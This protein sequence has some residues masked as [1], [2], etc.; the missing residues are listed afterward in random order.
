MKLGRLQ[1]LSGTWMCLALS[2][3][4]VL[5]QEPSDWPSFRGPDGKGVV[6]MSGEVESVPLR[7]Q[8]NA[9]PDSGSLDGILWKTDVPGLGH[10]SPVIAGNRIF[11]LTAI[12]STGDA[13]LKVG[14]GGRPEAADDNGEQRWVVLCYDKQTGK[15]LWRNVARQGI[16]K[17]T[18]HA[19]ATHANTS[20]AVAGEHVVA[21]FGSEGLYCYDLEG[22]LQWKRDLGVVDISKYGIGWGYAS[23]PAIYQDR[24]ALICD[25]PNNPYLAVLRLSDGRELWRVSRTDICER[26]WSTPL[27]HA[28]ANRTQIVINGWPWVVSYDLKS[29]GEL[30]RIKGGGDNPVPTPFVANNW[31]YLTS[32]HGGQSPIY[33][34]RP[35]A[36]GDVTPTKEQPSNDAIVWSTQRGGSYMST[37]VVY[38]DYL[39][40][41]NSNG[42]V[43]CYE[44]QTGKKMYE[45]RLGSDAGIIASLVAADNKVYCASENGTVYVIAAGPEYQ[46]L[47]ENPM[48]QPCFASPAISDGNLYFRTTT[49]LVAIEKPN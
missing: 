39:Y 12:A 14:G 9:D 49:A 38:G 11:V 30:W 46:L 20:V 29:G 2:W 17:A 21:F 35:T 34:V 7:D 16:P 26:N 41:G 31:I 42:V 10:S 48:G 37:P 13:P 22:N 44:A 40:L 1:I 15:E 5:A 8:W 4:T 19:K 36:T 45:K 6:S 24:I 28:T 32:S 25:D 18:R 33:V 3:A 43:R 27:I 23:S 47:A